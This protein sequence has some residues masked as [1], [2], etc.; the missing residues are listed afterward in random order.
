MILN[1]YLYISDVIIWLLLFHIYIFTGDRVNIFCYAIK[2]LCDAG[3]K[4]T[5]CYWQYFIIMSVLFLWPRRP[6]FIP[7]LIN[8]RQ[9][10]VIATRFFE[11][12]GTQV[13]NNLQ[14]ALFIVSLDV[15]RYQQ[16]VRW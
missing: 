7:L 13:A 11:G 14:T 4:L 16:G 15:L 3:L 12:G 1:G 5:L 8:E 2:S 10:F 9:E 6:L